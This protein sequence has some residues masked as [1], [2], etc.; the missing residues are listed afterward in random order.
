MIARSDADG[1][2]K[3]IESRCECYVL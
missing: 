2:L 1:E 3:C